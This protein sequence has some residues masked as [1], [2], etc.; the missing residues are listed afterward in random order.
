MKRIVTITLLCALLGVPAFA[1]DRQDCGNRI[2]V[3]IDPEQ[4][5]NPGNPDQPEDHQSRR[6][7][8]CEVEGQERKKINQA[9]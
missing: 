1:Q 2:Q 8:F 3:G 7:Q 9:G 4:T 6:H 5:Q